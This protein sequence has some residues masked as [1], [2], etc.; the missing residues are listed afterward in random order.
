MSSF[1]RP[2]SSKLLQGEKLLI[3]SLFDIKKPK[4]F[5]YSLLWAPLIM[6]K[7]TLLL[8]HGALLLIVV[9]ISRQLSFLAMIIVSICKFTTF[10]NL[11]YVSFKVF[12]Y[13]FP[14]HKK[15]ILRIFDSVFTLIHFIQDSGTS[16]P[17]RTPIPAIWYFVSL[18]LN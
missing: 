17:F 10:S 7:S 11:I 16:T 3:P 13:F 1:F 18:A 4:T 12:I 15:W 8:M 6:E 14:L 5:L 9:L 2:P